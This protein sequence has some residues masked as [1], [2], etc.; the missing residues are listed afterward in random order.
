M[1]P[2]IECIIVIVVLPVC[3][4][5]HLSPHSLMGI[6]ANNSNKRV[7]IILVGHMENCAPNQLLSPSTRVS[8]K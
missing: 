4:P 2:T 7:E 1:D 8:Q 5:A 3:T 6:A